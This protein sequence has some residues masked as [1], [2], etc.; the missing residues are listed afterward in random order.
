MKTLLLLSLF[1][2]GS[3]CLA[4]AQVVKDPLLDYYQRIGKPGFYREN[5]AP[6]F[7]YSP[8]TQLFSFEANFTGSKRKSLFITDSGQF[9]NDHANYDW[10]IYI[11]VGLIG[12]TMV[13][14]E[15]SLIMAGPEGPA[16]IGYIDQVKRYGIVDGDEGFVS[17]YYVENGVVQSQDLDQKSGHANET[18]YPKYFGPQSDDRPATTYTLAQLAK[19][20]ANPDP[21]NVVAPAAE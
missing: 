7:Q 18:Y 8:Q 2:C 5:N 20:Y 10:A 9:L 3:L 19:K 14:D 11:P 12:Y 13:T 15:S 6:G 4:Q 17:A 1:F 21:N 16:Y